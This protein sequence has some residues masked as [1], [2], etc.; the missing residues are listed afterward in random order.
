MI[1]NSPPSYFFSNSKIPVQQK[2]L[3]R[4]FKTNIKKEEKN[5]NN[6]GNNNN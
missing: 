2:K 3:K 4:I 6:N 5:D 1:S